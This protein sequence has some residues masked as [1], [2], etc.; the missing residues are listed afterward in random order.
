MIAGG[1]RVDSEFSWV[2]DILFDLYQQNVINGEE[3]FNL[4]LSIG[5]PITDPFE[6]MPD[7]SIQ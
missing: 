1:V 4:L 3:L 7:F 5:Q 2:S 6:N